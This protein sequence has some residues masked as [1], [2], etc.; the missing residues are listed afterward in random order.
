VF[1]LWRR[2]RRRIIP[3]VAVALLA[4]VVV[5]ILLLPASGVDAR[6]GQCYSALGYTVPCEAGVAMAS[7]VAAAA[8]AG[9]VAWWILG[10]SRPE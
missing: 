1:Q 2:S 3:A 6:P 5:C 10:R 9:A 8:V 4:G 7:A